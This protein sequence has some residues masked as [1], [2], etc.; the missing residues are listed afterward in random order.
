M[1]ANVPV[2]QSVR[3]GL[4]KD[5]ESTA[6]HKRNSTGDW[7]IQSGKTSMKIAVWGQGGERCGEAKGLVGEWVGFHDHK[8]FSYGENRLNLNGHENLC[9]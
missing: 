9:V 5:S 3:V 1:S 2:V 8:L 7:A 6:Y 4:V